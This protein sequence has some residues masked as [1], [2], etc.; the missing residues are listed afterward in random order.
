MVLSPFAV[1]EAVSGTFNKPPLETNLLKDK[2]GFKI[3]IK[4][5]FILGR[6][7]CEYH[8]E[9]INNNTERKATCR[10]PRKDPQMRRIPL[11][12]LVCFTTLSGQ[13]LPLFSR[14]WG[15]LDMDTANGHYWHGQQ[16][17]IN[18][19]DIHETLTQDLCRGTEPVVFSRLFN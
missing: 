11:G 3:F 9:N 10:L 6:T 16:K 17:I 5:I 7:F 2:V 1:K 8:P 15:I 4:C 18:F 12:L 14:G 19:L 13:N